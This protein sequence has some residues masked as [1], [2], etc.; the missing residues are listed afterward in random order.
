MLIGHGVIRCL[1]SSFICFFIV[2]VVISLASILF[3]NLFHHGTTI[4]AS[5]ATNQGQVHSTTLTVTG[6][7]CV[8]ESDYYEQKVAKLVVVVRVVTLLLL[9]SLLPLLLIV[10]VDGVSVVCIGLIVF[11]FFSLP[12]SPGLY[13]QTICCLVQL[14]LISYTDWL[15]NRLTTTKLPAAFRVLS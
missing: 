14:V 7:C 11:R 13:V 6:C 2:V 10:L 15:V 8:V 5:W 1:S 9:L 3:L 12:F 4:Q